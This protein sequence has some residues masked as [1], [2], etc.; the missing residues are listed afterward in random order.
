ME[1]AFETTNFTTT[2]HREPYAAILPTRPELSQLG[3]TVFITGGATGIGK[4]IAR[5]FVL[6]S[7]ATVIIVGRRVDKLKEAVTELEQLAKDNNRPTKIIAH[8]LDVTNLTK[9]NGIWDKLATNG[10]NVDVLVLNAVKFTEAQTLIEL[11]VEEVWSQFETNVKAPLLLAER[12]YKQTSTSQKVTY[13]QYA[14]VPSRTSINHYLSQFLINVTTGSIHMLQNDIVAQRPSYSLTKAS[15]TLAVQLLAVT[16]PADKMQI[17]NFHPGLI[18]GEGWVAMGV[19][20]DALPFDEGKSS[21]F[22]A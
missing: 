8:V 12:F 1:E 5:N 20:K 3:K 2:V 10:T 13:F 17:L 21:Y 6:A 19:L 4:A 7:A 15:S 22:R 14:L 9:V 16:I 11:G 18:Y